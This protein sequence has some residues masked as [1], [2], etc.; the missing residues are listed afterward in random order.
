MAA[1]LKRLG[2][3]SQSVADEVSS[4]PGELTAI[5]MQSR[6]FNHAHGITGFL[7]WRNGYYFQ[8]LEGP[9]PA[10][11]SLFAKIA[12]DDRHCQ[13]ATVWS[14]LGVQDRIF[15]GWR[16]KL[17]SASLT[18]S[19]VNRYI[20]LYEDR[21]D[22]LDEDIQQRL[23]KIFQLDLIFSSEPGD[24]PDRHAFSDY[25]FRLQ[26]LPSVF[27]LTGQH[28]HCIDVLTTLLSDWISP[29]QLSEKFKLSLDDLYDLMSRCE[30]NSL[31]LKRSSESP[32]QSNEKS[33]HG[34]MGESPSYSRS[35]Y[36]RLRAVFMAP[37]Q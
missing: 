25:Q 16:L 13:I 34:L 27:G 21:F 36:D 29:A 5:V 14:E 6:R 7:T 3:V 28:P 23:S 19:E 15:S 18:C 31:L 9:T 11:D 17:W 12:N 24:L 22:S 32:A 2:Y 37:Y 33:S 26:A 35:F 30:V 20:R 10:V 1:E 8:A 4:V